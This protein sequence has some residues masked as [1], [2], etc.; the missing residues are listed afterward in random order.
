MSTSHRRLATGLHRSRE[1]NRIGSE[2]AARSRLGFDKSERLNLSSKDVRAREVS[3]W[4]ACGTAKQNL[5]CGCL[6]PIP[7][8]D[9]R[10]LSGRRPRTASFG[11]DDRTR[12]N[13][14]H[15]SDRKP[16][17][18]TRKRRRSLGG[19]GEGSVSVAFRSLRTWNARVDRQVKAIDCG[20]PQVP[21]LG[22][23]IANMPR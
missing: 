13:R 14:N 15:P 21:L 6:W 2:L 12:E 20:D 22:R 23:Q 18:A 9:D 4:G 1:T 3:N 19:Q 16:G 7:G 10:Q 8:R 5:P 17:A 11:R